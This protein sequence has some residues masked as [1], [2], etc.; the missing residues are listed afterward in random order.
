VL[1]FSRIEVKIYLLFLLSLFFTSNA[2]ADRDEYITPFFKEDGEAAGMFVCLYLGYEFSY[3]SDAE[4]LF[5]KI[6]DHFTLSAELKSN[7]KEDVKN[8]WTKNLLNFEEP[9]SDIQNRYWRINCEEPTQNMREF[10][11]DKKVD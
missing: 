2:L 1:Y 10:F 9:A 6:T 11:K 5:N 7:I 3:A 8:Y 4:E